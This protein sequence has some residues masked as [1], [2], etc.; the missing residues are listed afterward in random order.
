MQNQEDFLLLLVATDEALSFSSFTRKMQ[1]CD[2]TSKKTALGECIHSIPIN[3]TFQMK[4]EPEQVKGRRRIY[5]E[6]LC[7]NLDAKQT[8]IQAT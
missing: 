1:S 3:Q 4:P 7:A 6:F 5:P 2:W 8:K